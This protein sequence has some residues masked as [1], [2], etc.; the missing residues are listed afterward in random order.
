M[1]RELNCPLKMSSSIEKLDLKCDE[2]ECAWWDDEDEQCVMMSQMYATSAIAD[3]LEE[4]KNVLASPDD[5]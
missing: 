2:E 4:I 5:D 1:A 3:E